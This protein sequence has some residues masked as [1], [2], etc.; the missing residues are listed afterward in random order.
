MMNPKKEEL[1]AILRRCDHEAD[2]MISYDEF[3]EIVSSN[4]DK[5]HNDNVDEN[6]YHSDSKRQ[7]EKDI[8][9]SPLKK[10]G[11]KSDLYEKSIDQTLE[12]YSPEDK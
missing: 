10:S 8:K 12:Q 7:L 3:C 9:N 1:E 4:D 5:L 6:L 11:S 2:Q